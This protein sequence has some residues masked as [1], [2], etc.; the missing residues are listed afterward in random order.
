[1]TQR[2]TRTISALCFLLT[3]AVASGQAQPSGNQLKGDIPCPF[4]VDF[5]KGE[6]SCVGRQES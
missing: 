1:M 3:L 2:I 4:V 6:Q 5:S